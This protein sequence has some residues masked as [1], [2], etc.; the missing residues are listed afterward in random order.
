[1]SPLKSWEDE[2]NEIIL[3]FN[4][5]NIR[6]IIALVFVSVDDFRESN[7]KNAKLI[8]NVGHV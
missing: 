7:I 5:S 6:S 3:N 1:M 2:L 8:N 4:Y